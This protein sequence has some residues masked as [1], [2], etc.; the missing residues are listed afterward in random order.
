MVIRSALFQSTRPYGARHTSVT[1]HSMRMFQSTR[2]YGARRSRLKRSHDRRQ[3]FNPRARTG[4]D[5]SI[6][7]AV[8]MATGFQSTRPYGARRC[9]HRP[10]VQTSFN[11]RA[12]TGRDEPVRIV[13]R[14]S[15]VSIHAPV[16]G[17]TSS[18]S[19]R[20]IF[21]V[22]IHAP[23]RGATT[24]S[25]PLVRDRCFNPRARTGRDATMSLERAHRCSVSIHAP[26][27]GATYAHRHDAV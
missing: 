5:L 21:D 18:S 13:D 17:A 15:V 27:R 7:S 12:R 9:G 11:R 16:R 23:V 10:I 3:C 19:S 6:V 26:V 14:A 1:R 4:R 22:S 2:P 24:S 8:S 20:A 25:A